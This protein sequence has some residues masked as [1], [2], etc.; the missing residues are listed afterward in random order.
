MPG[1]RSPSEHTHEVL[2]ARSA[3]CFD[4]FRHGMDGE[5]SEVIEVVGRALLGHRQQPSLQLVDVLR[6]LRS[7]THTA[8]VTR[9]LAMRI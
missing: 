1:W 2:D 6:V 4:L 7:Q 9:T 5:A 3:G 8:V